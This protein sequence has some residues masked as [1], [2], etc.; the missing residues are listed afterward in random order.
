MDP[1]TLL[2][3]GSSA[4]ESLSGLASAGIELAASIIDLIAAAIP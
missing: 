4:L 3:A 2:Q 1:N